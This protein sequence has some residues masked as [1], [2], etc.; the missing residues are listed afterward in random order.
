MSERRWLPPPRWLPPSRGGGDLAACRGCGKSRSGLL[1]RVGIGDPSG[2]SPL[3]LSLGGDLPG[4]GGEASDAMVEARTRV[5]VREMFTSRSAPESRLLRPGSTATATAATAG[6]T[7]GSTTSS[8]TF[9]PAQQPPPPPCARFAGAMACEMAW[10]G[11]RGTAAA[12]GT[13]VKKCTSRKGRSPTSCAIWQPL[14]ASPSTATTRSPRRTSPSSAAGP[15]GTIVT[16]MFAASISR[17]K[18]WW[19]VRRTGTCRSLA[20]GTRRGEASALNSAS[21]GA[22]PGMPSRPDIVAPIGSI[23]KLEAVSTGGWASVPF[24]G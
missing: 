24:G 10:R 14:R 12:P 5:R 2:R 13:R 3:R 17:P 15:S 6:S 7:L 23:G 21:V 19:G 20:S 22:M 11:V 16:M 8:A 1:T 4:G 18:P 9:L